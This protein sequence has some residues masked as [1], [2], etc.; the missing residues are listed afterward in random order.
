MKFHD[1]ES[2]L[3]CFVWWPPSI[4]LSNLPVFQDLDD[5]AKLGPRISASAHNQRAIP[6]MARKSKQSVVEK[7]QNYFQNGDL[8]DWQRLCRDLGLADDLPSKKKCRAV[9]P[10]APVGSAH[11]PEAAR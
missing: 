1:P 10:P 8:A 3:L 6:A 11:V 5:E 4:S 7:W 9:G 2:H